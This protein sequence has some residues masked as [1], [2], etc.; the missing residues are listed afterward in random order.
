MLVL[1]ALVGQLKSLI[2]RLVFSLQRFVLLLEFLDK[3]RLAVLHFLDSLVELGLYLGDHDLVGSLSLVFTIA[4]R[5]L[6]LLYSRL[7]L[8]LSVVEVLLGSVS[9][10]LKELELAFPESLVS[11]VRV[12]LV[13]MESLHL[14]VLSPPFFNLLLD[15]LLITRES[16][17]KLLICVS[18]LGDLSFAV[19]NKLLLLCL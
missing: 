9:L 12:I 5:S 8:S 6:Q 14:H 19:L 15:S 18:K 2:E 11:V 17:V 13:R 7:K 1:L 10:L 4:L 3:H 16:H